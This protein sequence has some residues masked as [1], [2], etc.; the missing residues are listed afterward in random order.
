[1]HLYD[2]FILRTD[3]PF[4]TT[5][6][7]KVL[8]V[9]RRAVYIEGHKG[10]L[11]LGEEEISFRYGKR[12]LVIKGKKLYLKELAPDEGYVFGEIEALEVVDA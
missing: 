8:L 2:Q 6:G 12:R 10:L 5:V 3:Q 1:M 9:D 4:D 7:S 11:T